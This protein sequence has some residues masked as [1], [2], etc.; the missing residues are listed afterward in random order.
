[1][2]LH[3]IK[4]K[5]FLSLRD[6]CITGLDPHLN[7]IV[8]PNGSGKTNIFRLLKT[9]RDVFIAAG[10]G[11]TS[12][13]GPLCTQGVV[14][15]EVDV[16]LTVEFDTRWEQELISAFLCTT[17]SQPN[18]LNTALARL[19]SQG[20]V[21]LSRAEHLFFA[22]WL[23]Q[24]IRPETVRC[25]FRGDLRV[26]YSSDIYDYLRLSYTFVC[27]GEPL[28]IIMGSLAGFDGTFWRGDP[29]E[30]PTQGQRPGGDM[31]LTFLWEPRTHKGPEEG[32]PLFEFFNQ[33]TGSE[34][35]ALDTEV[36]LL[37]LADQKGFLEVEPLAQQYATLPTYRTL[38]E[39]SGID[40]RQ[41]NARK[42]IFSTLFSLLINRAWVFTNNVRLP[43][44]APTELDVNKALSPHDEQQIPL[45]LFR[46]KIG[47]PLEQER[48]QRIQDSFSLLVGE[49]RRFDLTVKLLPQQSAGDN[50]L[51]VKLLSQPSTSAMQPTLD[52]RVMD[53]TGDISLAYQ[54][55][56]V[57]EALV[58]STLLDESEGRL[59]LL[60]E[61]AANLHPGMQH[62]LIEIL[63]GAPG[64]V[65]AVTHSAHLLPTLADEFQSVYRLQKS[66]LG[67]QVFRL[68]STFA[69]QED[70]L[71]NELR[72]SSDI[73]GLLF[74][75]GVLL[76]EGPTEIGA[77]STWFLQTSV[78]QGKTFADLN[79]VLHAL[80]GKAEIP[81]YLRFLTAFVVPWA[82][83][84][85]G[86]A[87]LPPNTSP[88]D[89]LWKVL[90]ELQLLA[91]VP[92]GTTSFDTLKAQAANAGV[93]TYNTSSP[94]KF[95]TVPEVKNFL[96]T[97]WAPSSKTAYGGR[98]IAQHLTCPQVVDE[99]LQQA[100][101][102]LIGKT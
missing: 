99:V 89:K 9:I 5:N 45:W 71:E 18:V 57:W 85:D 25:F 70:K 53:A 36:F 55:A 75:N 83:I 26:T 41:A 13:L 35:A 38:S 101:K 21:Q 92:S 44:S 67:T 27:K 51:T 4:A 15:Q 2:R 62:K 95:E 20:S 96:D 76:V 73:A 19:Q 100:V 54:G 69:T 82:V 79:F 34:P 98:Y 10:T 11:R 8:G 63:R 80:N 61:P 97:D 88:N 14:P 16:S 28:T 84:C 39:A 66:H 1:M 42:L 78:S 33:Q 17:L 93:Y 102:R 12:S 24:Q 81:F 37:F 47:D 58:L 50:N 52:I 90:K 77:F 3:G 32:G 30:T 29:P 59:V 46:L 94:T 6:C 48:F 23:A 22:E 87:L 64:Q 72:A 43:F 91:E 40:F 56:G 86:D 74:A 7:F 68:G 60:D 65:L 31:L 49:D